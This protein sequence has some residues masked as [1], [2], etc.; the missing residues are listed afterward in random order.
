MSKRYKLFLGDCLE[1]MKQ[2][3][4]NSIHAIITDFP[5]GTLKQKKQM[6]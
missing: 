6:G 1:V 5:Y 2:I 3:L 4:D